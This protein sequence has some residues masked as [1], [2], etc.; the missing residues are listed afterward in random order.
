MLRWLWR[1]F[2][3]VALGAAVLF[4][5][6]VA[7]SAPAAALPGKT[8][9]APAASTMPSGDPLTPA[10]QARGRRH[11]HEARLISL[12]SLLYQGA[13][14]AGFFLLGGVRWLVRLT[15]RIDRHWLLQLG[16][17]AGVLSL[18][19][20]VLFLPLDYYAGFVFPHRYGLSTQT[21]AA[22]WQDYALSTAVGVALGAPV[23][24]GFYALLRRFPR[25]WWRWVTAAS[26]PLS[27][28]LLLIEPVFIA[29]LFNTFTPLQHA[30]LRADILAMARRQ[31]IAAH[32]VYQMDASRRSRAVNAYVNGVGP[33][34]RIVLYDTL[35]AYFT[36]AETQCVMA[37][38]MGHY[39][40]RHIPWGIALS[41]LGTLAG[42]FALF[43][44]AHAILRRWGGRLGVHDPAHPAAYP[45]LL[46]LG[47]ALA[48]AA[49]PVAAYISRRMER[50]ADAFALRIHPD[51]DASISTYH[52]LAR[53]NVADE[54]PPRWAIWL[55]GSHPSLG[56]RIRAV[57]AARQ[58]RSE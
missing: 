22:W 9:F 56:E 37:H 11:G 14:L 27:L 16:A 13:L 21:P 50:Q 34:Q 30:A 4:G 58:H 35:L 45:L 31:G 12:V 5:A 28:F 57:E 33:S 1:Q 54:E 36:P 24:A 18:A 52:K 47:L 20:A 38:E 23:L 6:L 32:E 26:L 40:L 8:R 15:E 39:V 48:L 44:L 17:V 2:L 19:G 53:L 51:Y 46:A 29:P 7:A 43:R 25:T 3:T 55:A 41:V 10:E 42:S 49:T